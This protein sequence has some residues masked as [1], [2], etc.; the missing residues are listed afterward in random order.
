MG[1]TVQA[2]LPHGKDVNAVF[3]LEYVFEEGELVVVGH[4]AMSEL[5]RESVVLS[6][7]ELRR[8]G[9]LIVEVETLAMV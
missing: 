7:W 5:Y 3:C 8:R 9:D 4:A 1:K 6:D 2:G